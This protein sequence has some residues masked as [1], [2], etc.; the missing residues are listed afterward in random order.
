LCDPVVVPMFRSFVLIKNYPAC[1]TDLAS[2]T[3]RY[4]CATNPFGDFGDLIY[5]ERLAKL[6][7]KLQLKD[8]SLCLLGSLFG[9]ALCVLQ[10]LL[11]IRNDFVLF[12][13][14]QT[15]FLVS[16]SL[17]LLFNL[18]PFLIERSL[19][20]QFKRFACFLKLSLFL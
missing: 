11:Q 3:L 18:T 14:P 8:F 16:P 20:T 5:R 1:S 19:N 2:D 9:C 4:V 12:C 17:S 10:F 7:L 15:I 13:D 6:P